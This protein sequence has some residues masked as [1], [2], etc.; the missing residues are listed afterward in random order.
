L[1]FT[2]EFERDLVLHSGINASWSRWPC[3]ETPRRSVFDHSKPDIV[4]SQ[5]L[6][7]SPPKDNSSWK[8]NFVC[9]ARLC[10]FAV[11]ELHTAF[12][13]EM[14]TSDAIRLGHVMIRVS[15]DWSL[16]I[17]HHPREAILSFP[18]CRS[19]LS[20]PGAVRNHNAHRNY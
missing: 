11:R 2:Q 5:R 12:R 13:T 9:G 7:H 1:R 6:Y 15:L 4:D 20:K 8:C 17:H 3:R 14:M 18:T 16:L 19:N 10:A